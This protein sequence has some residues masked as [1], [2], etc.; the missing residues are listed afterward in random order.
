M[1]KKFLSFFSVLRN[2]IRSKIVIG[3]IIL[4]IFGVGGYLLF[5]RSPTYQFVTVKSGSITESVSLTGNTVPVKSV[6]LGFGSSGVISRTYSD[7]GKKVYAGQVLA[8][9]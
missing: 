6:S 4:L 7:L 2:L 5:H 9:L 3:I 1:K 8:Q